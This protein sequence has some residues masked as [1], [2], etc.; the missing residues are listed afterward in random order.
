MSGKNS[1][2]NGIKRNASYNKRK[3]A[4]VYPNPITHSS[5]LGTG[6]GI[7]AVIAVLA[8]IAAFITPAGNG[9]IDFFNLQGFYAGLTWVGIGIMSAG[10][11]AYL[12]RNEETRGK[13]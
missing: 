8:A 2:R 9:F 13:L 6:A 5:S 7:I 12:A 3:P 1:N 4:T 11:A 10:I